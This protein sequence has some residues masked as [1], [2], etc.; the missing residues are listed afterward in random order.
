MIDEHLRTSQSKTAF[1]LINR[2]SI[3]HPTKRDGGIMKCYLTTQD[4]E[5]RIG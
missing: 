1:Q 4:N 5:L 3:V 2:L